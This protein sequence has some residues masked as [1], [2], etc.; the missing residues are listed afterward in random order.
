MVGL[1]AEKITPLPENIPP[2]GVA[3]KLIGFILVVTAGIEFIDA[4][5]LEQSVF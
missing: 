1:K 4:V 5:T 3:D 2:E